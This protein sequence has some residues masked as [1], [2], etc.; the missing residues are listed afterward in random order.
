MA[1][2]ESRGA[3]LKGVS[4]FVVLTE[5]CGGR[6]RHCPANRRRSPRVVITDAYA[7][8]AAWSVESCATAKCVSALSM[9]LIAYVICK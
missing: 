6:P 3:T 5:A 9:S 1:R 2:H 7:E 4:A 8:V